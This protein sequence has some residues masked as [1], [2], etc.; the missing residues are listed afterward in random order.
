MKFNSIAADSLESSFDPERDVGATR[1]YP[2][3]KNKI[4]AER[5]SPHG[6]WFL[7]FE[8]G[9]VPD[10]LSGSYTSLSFVEKAIEAY[11]ALKKFEEAS[12][13]NGKPRK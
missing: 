2:F 7:H 6:L 13:S 11:F 10:S 12:I 1:E 9:T 8:H 5:K 4:I 3:E